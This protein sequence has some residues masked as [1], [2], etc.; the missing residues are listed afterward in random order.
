MKDNVVEFLDSNANEGPIQFLIQGL[1]NCITTWRAL[2]RSNY[3]NALFKLLIRSLEDFTVRNQEADLPH[4]SALSKELSVSLLTVYRSQLKTSANLEDYIETSFDRLARILKTES[5]KSFLSNKHQGTVHKPNIY[6]LS[7]KNLDVDHCKQHLVAGGFAVKTFS[8]FSLLLREHLNEPVDHW[9]VDMD[10]LS[11]AEIREL[12]VLRNQKLGE[13]TLTL[14]AP[15]DS[16]NVRTVAAK[17]AVDALICQSLNAVEL[18]KTFYRHE[19]SIH[20]AFNPIFVFSVSEK[21]FL[22]YEVAARKLKLEVECVGT[23]NQLVDKSQQQK[24]SALVLCIEG[25]LGCP[26]ELVRC[27]QLE[28]TL[29][30]TPIIV[31]AGLTQDK[32]HLPMV[33]LGVTDFVMNTLTP[34]WVLEIASARKVYSD[35]RIRTEEIANYMDLDTGVVTEDRFLQLLKYSLKQRQEKDFDD[36]GALIHL[37]YYFDSREIVE[38]ERKSLLE[39]NGNLRH[40]IVSALVDE[41]ETRDLIGVLGSEDLCVLVYRETEDSLIAFLEDLRNKIKQLSLQLFG[42]KNVI[43][44]YFGA[45][46]LGQKDSRQLLTEAKEM[47]ARASNGGVSE[48]ALNS[49]NLTTMD[50]PQKQKVRASHASLSELRSAIN[51]QRLS[52]VYQPIVT[53]DNRA[54]KYEVYLRVRDINE[55]WMQTSEVIHTAK[56]YGLTR[57]LDRWVINEVL[58]EYSSNRLNGINHK[59]LF[60]K[61]T[62]DSFS[63]HKFIPWV[64][65][66]LSIKNI[67]ARFICLQISMEDVS[68][69]KDNAKHF[70]AQCKSIGVAVSVEKFKGEADEI[71]KV[72]SLWSLIQ[73]VKLDANYI[74]RLSWDARAR[75]GFIDFRSFCGRSQIQIVAPFVESEYTHKMFDR[76]GVEL[77]Q[78]YYIQ[79]PLEQF[80]IRKSVS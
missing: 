57:F 44:A 79:K 1:K 76:M 80:Q 49:V 46:R 7:A 26:V 3:D 37:T 43:K 72:E 50:E 14:V 6:Y 54:D 21:A 48:Y 10:A 65:K 68:I 38:E 74:E 56:T 53:R 15:E 16:E 19:C 47:T 36:W 40:C 42:S 77:M 52:L 18:V 31:C 67:N 75:H 29:V 60:I 30:D 13:Y 35:T 71:A 73:Y 41:L 9:L 78:G 59:S 28:E 64:E 8:Q 5:Q 4:A 70:L 25:Y 17:L 23:Y 32:Y 61:V 39:T 34:K 55:N 12:S 69:A 62:R 66:Q 58:S 2:K 33:Q 27:L 45:S 11:S 63:D 20:Q 24:P 51:D 22:Q